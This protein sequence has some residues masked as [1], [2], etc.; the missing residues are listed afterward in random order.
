MVVVCVMRT[1]NF[2]WHTFLYNPLLNAL[3]A[4]YNGPAGQNLGIAVIE[5]TVLIR[6]VLLPF[7]VI[8]VRAHHRYDTL[9]HELGHI[10]T[11]YRN[12]RVRRKQA[13]RSLLEK[14]NIKPW[15]KAFIFGMQFI[16]LIV[17]Y[18][19]FVDAVRGNDFTGLYAWNQ[20]PD[21][22]NRSFFGFDLAAH[23]IIWASIVGVLVYFDVWLER[24]HNRENLPN[25]DVF[26]RIGFP[27]AIFLVLYALPAAKSIFVLTSFLFSLLIVDG[28]EKMFH[29]KT[30]IAD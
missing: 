18:R 25:G 6:I 22:L 21:F 5:L 23:S 8:A 24:R 12:D 17:L 19:V 27:I 15:P 13:L 20:A 3:I 11:S 28:F 9:R 2:L 4:L 29:K 7:T 14:H 26:Y 1:M 30:S 16:V 10:E